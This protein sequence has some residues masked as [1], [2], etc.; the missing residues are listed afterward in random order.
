MKSHN[1]HIDGISYEVPEGMTL[2]ELASHPDLDIAFA[3]YSGRCGMCRVKILDGAEFLNPLTDLEEIFFS[4]AQAIENDRLAC[5]CKPNG[6]VSLS[7]SLK[8]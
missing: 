6:P 8:K 1:I 3:C 4:N 5:Q 2:L 7:A